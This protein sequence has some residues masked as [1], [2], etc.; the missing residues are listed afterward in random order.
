MLDYMDLYLPQPPSVRP[1]VEVDDGK[2]WLRARG[3]AVSS[4]VDGGI[5]EVDGAVFMQL[6]GYMSCEEMERA[7]I[8]RYVTFFTAV[9][10][11][12][13]H[14]VAEGR[15]GLAVATAGVG[16]T[17]NVAVA[18][19]IEPDP[20]AILDAFRL[21]AEAKAVVAADLGLRRGGRR[22]GGDVS[23][24]VAVIATGG[25]RRR[26]VGLGTEVGDELFRLVHDVVLKA[27][28]G[29]ELDFELR[30]YLGL[31]Y[32]DLLK[33]TVDT[34]NTAPVPGVLDVAEEARRVLDAVLA[35]PN[36]W[37]FIYAAGELDAKGSA[38][39]FRGLA[40]EEHGEDSKRI[41]ADESLGVALAE[42]IGGFKAVLTLYWLDRLKPGPLSRLSMFADDVA[43]AIVAGV[44]TRLYDKLLHGL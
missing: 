27:M 29:L 12:R 14:A 21:V 35:D 25:E 44:L 16:N 41:V 43:A 5:R 26:Y 10:L 2:L 17:I 32:G 42:Y 23:D 39:T 30:A 7:A 22:V 6:R 9:D 40:R 1:V 15:W 20:R 36:V 3:V 37:A 31:G 4:T 24:A 33:L 28:G 8:P 34:Y 18:L 19:S 13:H 38:G 11:V